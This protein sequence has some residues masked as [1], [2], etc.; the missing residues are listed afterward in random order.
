MKPNLSAIS[1]VVFILAGLGLG[2]WTPAVETCAN[3]LSNSSLRALPNTTLDSAMLVSDAFTSPGGTPAFHGLPSFCRVSAT[4]KPTPVSDIKIEVWM[5]TEGWNQKLQGVGNGGLAGTISYGALAQATKE[6]YASISTDTGHVASDTS[7]L[8]VIERE[9]DYGYRAIHGMTT[10]A[11]AIVQQFYGSAPRRSY[12]NGCSTGGGQGFGETQLYPEDYDGILSG[13]PQDYPTHVRAGLIWEFQ[14]ATNNPASNLPKE[15]LGLVTSAVLK[16]CGGQYGASD[17]FLSDPRTCGFD[18]ERLVCKSGQDSSGCL[19]EAQ[20]AAIKKIYGGAISPRTGK[21]IWPGLMPG[22]EAPAGPGAVGW[23]AASING[24]T[25]FSTGTQFYSLAVFENRNLDFHTVDLDDALQAAEK[26]FPFLDH[27]SMDIDAFTKRGGKLLIYHGWADPMIAPLNSINYYGT[28]VETVGLKKR[29]DHQAALKETE[30]SARLFMVPGM[31]I[32][33]VGP[34]Q[35][36][37]TQSA[38]STRGWIVVWS[39]IN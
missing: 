2:V 3:L 20:A 24:P 9:K 23:Q 8:P 28:L 12:F 36:P 18:P 16:E 33:P 29:M 14:A 17:G 34:A 32:A 1:A 25:P 37:S 10:T 7:W 39:R 35:T 22:S 5:P 6:G 15:K 31:G 38:R 13:A 26:K 19:S 30:K 11:K 21:L 27:I 4:L